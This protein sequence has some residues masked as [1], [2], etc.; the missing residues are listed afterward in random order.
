MLLKHV[1]LPAVSPAALE[2]LFKLSP[3]LLA[4]ILMISIFISVKIYERKDL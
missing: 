1:T 3:V 4:A 2:M